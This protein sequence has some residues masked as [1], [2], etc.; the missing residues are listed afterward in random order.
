MV[1]KRFYGEF[2]ILG[3]CGYGLFLGGKGGGTPMSTRISNSGCPQYNPKYPPNLKPF[4][5]KSD[6]CRA[7]S[8]TTR[9]TPRVEREPF[10]V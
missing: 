2:M 5:E 1:L 4:T 3:C 8:S 9:C 7:A 10:R 6:C